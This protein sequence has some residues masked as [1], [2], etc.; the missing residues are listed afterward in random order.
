MASPLNKPNSLCAYTTGCIEHRCTWQYPALTEQV[1]KSAP[2]LGN[3]CLPITVK[4]VIVRCEFVIERIQSYPLNLC[5]LD[6][7][8]GS[9]ADITDQ[10][11]IRSLIVIKCLGDEL[12]QRRALLFAQSAK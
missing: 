3:G 4:Q 1:G 9:K 10:G 5:T 7:R 12:L 11:S 6:V 8:F 2:L